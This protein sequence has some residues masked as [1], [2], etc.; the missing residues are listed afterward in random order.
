MITRFISDKSFDTMNIEYPFDENMEIS[1][2]KIN[3]DGNLN[4]NI[5]PSLKDTKDIKSNNYTLTILSRNDNLN[6]FLDYKKEF[7]T[8]NELFLIYYNNSIEVNETAQFWE[9]IDY[10]IKLEGSYNDL[11]ETNMFLVDFLDDNKCKIYHDRNNLKNILAYSISLSSLKVVPLT[12]E[13]INQYSTDFNYIKKDNNIIFYVQTDIGNFSIQKNGTVLLIKETVDFENG[14]NFYLKNKNELNQLKNINNWISYENTFNK[15]NLQVSETRSHF[16]IKN[17]HLITSPINSISAFIPVNI[18][19]LKNQLNQ[20]N[21]QSR[22]NVIIGDNET[23]IKEYEGIF[24]GGYREYGYD[25]INLGYTIY[26]T[27]LVFKSGKTTYFHVPHEI[28]PYEKLNVNS[29]KLAESGSVGG[30]CPLNSDKIWKKLKDYR[31]TSP[32]SNPR[33]E[34][35]GQWLCTWLS[36]GNSN[37]R[38]IWVDR[39]YKPSKTTTYV[40]M[41]AI[42]TEIIYKDSF[43]CL[44]LKNDI[45]D[46]KSSLTFEKGVYYAYMH[47][48]KKDYVNL[49]NESLSSKIYHTSLDLYKNNNFLDLEAIG[50]EYVF[51]G[52]TFG[53]IESDKKIEQNNA[54]FSFFLEKDDWDIPSGNIIFGNYVNGGFG[55]YNYILNTPYNILKSNDNAL[56]VFNNSFKKIENLSTENLTLCSISGISR[57]NGFENIHVFTSDFRLIEIDLRGTI[58]D[59]NSTVKSILS[60]SNSDK[61][62]SIT[63]DEKYSYV[64]TTNGIAKVDLDNNN[65]YIKTEKTT[66]GSGTL[67]EIIVDGNENLYKVYGTQSILRNN[68]IYCL[69]GGKIS[70]YST[71]LSVLSNYIESDYAIDCFGITKDR[72]VNFISNNEFYIYA[73][74]SF[75][76]FTTIEYLSTYSLSA[77]QISYCEKFEYGELKKIKNIFC[78]NSTES[79]IIQIDDNYNQN[80]IKLDKKY[81][82]IQSNMDIGNYNHNIQYLSQMYNDKT[83]HFKVK[84]LN[85]VNAEDH[86]E[87]IFNIQ[88]SDLSTG[89]RHFVFSIDCYNGNANFYLDGQLYSTKTFE[90]RKYIISNTFNNRIFYGTNPFFNGVPA[91]KHMKDP[92]DFICSKLKLTENHILNKALDNQEVIYF[93]SKVYPPND[94]KYNMPSGVRSFIDNMEKVFNFNIPMF[95][96]NH[97]GMRILNSGIVFDSLRK[98]LEK[99]IIER[100]NDFLP[101]YTEL[102]GIEWAET[103]KPTIAEGDYSISNEL[104]NFKLK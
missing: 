27:P 38:P 76:S 35:T 52:K 19:T 50:G 102:D 65:V 17:N 71:S 49:I 92:R 82:I 62:Y 6:N 70:T 67:F 90:K 56:S 25:K 55:F 98:D 94:L 47:L 8:K 29:S 103:M 40:A 7:D 91:F 54:T 60:L 5:I 10:S 37:T 21:D 31:D 41:S 43:D 69:S 85:K 45:S 59:S 39:Y 63:N 78:Q 32:Y 16:N 33:E 93:Y 96:S 13:N 36:A 20:E 15:N 11:N 79:Y 68:D 2:I 24:T 61:I 75:E 77:K 58:V 23:S 80:L 26:S 72:E 30:N 101:Y 53:Y 83:Y 84:L 28:Y 14:N 22:G 99:Y 64:S 3:V 88:S 86:T 4:Y 81:D 100:I 51:D 18:M 74:D 1:N 95:K 42:A 104:T 57:R 89:K 34:N 87:I 44:D 66:I 73:D 48:G 46:V 9:I 97:F 12:A